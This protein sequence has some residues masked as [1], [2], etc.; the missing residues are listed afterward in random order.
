MCKTKQIMAKKTTPTKQIRET[1]K[2]KQ[3]NQKRV[4]S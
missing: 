4:Q 1:D 3:T 2:K